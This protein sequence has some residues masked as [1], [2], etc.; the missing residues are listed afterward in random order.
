MSTSNY[1]K[2]DN[3]ILRKNKNAAADSPA[4]TE[5]KLN[6]LKTLNRSFSGFIIRRMNSSVT[7]RHTNVA[8]ASINNVLQSSK[9]IVRMSLLVICFCVSEIIWLMYLCQCCMIGSAPSARL[10][11]T[12]GASKEA[13]ITINAHGIT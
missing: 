13:S 3:T 7:A 10:R 5:S 8:Y 6:C 4:N 9:D 12:R 1:F 2:L 11:A